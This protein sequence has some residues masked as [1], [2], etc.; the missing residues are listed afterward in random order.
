MNVIAI[1]GLPGSGKS[2]TGAVAAE[3]DIPVVTM[4]DVEFCSHGTGLALAAARQ[5]DDSDN[6]H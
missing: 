5:T 1:V 3:L 4:G 6:V 2:E